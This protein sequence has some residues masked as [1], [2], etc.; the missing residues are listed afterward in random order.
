MNCPKCGADALRTARFCIRCGTPLKASSSTATEAASTRPMHE[1][2]TEWGSADA[3]PRLAIGQ[4]LPDNYRVEGELGIGGMGAVYLVRDN[5]TGRPF[6]VKTTRVADDAHRRG[7]LKE[8]QIWIDLPEHPNLVTCRFFRTIEDQVLI[9]ADYAN[10]G[11]LADAISRRTMTHLEQMLDVAIQFAWGLHAAHEVGVIHRDVKP[12]NVLLHEDGV[13]KITDFGISSAR[14][15]ATGQTVSDGT[16]GTVTSGAMTL[17]YRS[18]EQAAGKSL[19][20]ATDLWSWGVSLLEMFSGERTWRLGEV[21]DALLDQY[22]TI[23]PTALQ[24]PPMPAAVADLLRKCFRHDPDERW[25]DM[26]SV[27][28]MLIDIY[29]DVAGRAY[30]RQTP[31]F[32]RGPAES[33]DYSKPLRHEARDAEHWLRAALS[34]A[35]RDPNEAVSRLRKPTRLQAAR[36]VQELAAFDEA[37][38]MLERLVDEGQREQRDRL[39]KLCIDEGYVLRLAGDHNGALRLFDRS[40]AILERLLEASEELDYMST[41]MLATVEKGRTLAF[42]GRLSEAAEVFDR[43]I[44]Y[45]LM[46]WQPERYRMVRDYPLAQLFIAKGAVSFQERDYVAAGGLFSR[47]IDILEDM[48]RVWPRPDFVECLC[49]AYRNHSTVLSRQ[50][51]HEAAM[52]SSDRAVEAARM[53]RMK[54]ETALSD[55]D[56]AAVLMDRAAVLRE[57]GDKRSA[58]D[59]CER[60]VKLYERLVNTEGQQVLMPQLAKGYENLAVMMGSSGDHKSSLTM[61]D[62]AIALMTDLVRDH[63]RRDLEGTLAYIMVNRAVPLRKMRRWAEVISYLD[64]VIAE[65]KRLIEEEERVELLHELALAY[66]DQAYSFFK[67]ENPRSATDRFQRACQIWRVLVHERGRREL[68]TYLDK[69]ESNLRNLS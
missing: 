41:L 63:G 5:A 43:A 66:S 19:G 68:A 50:G 40:I 37:R 22:L 6:A 52:R 55:R 4:L 64:R 1:K 56:L 33:I 30:P 69:A 26:L 7:F 28:N 45:T 20:R 23:G 17:P 36:I 16:S 11:S 12:A 61:Y 53:L 18:P 31:D 67:Q 10:G 13:V 15:L 14:A 48:A 34:A 44:H 47:A 62:R 51:D 49:H 46:R 65:L 3:A 2:Q 8:L 57:R 58:R 21:A 32:V 59:V 24:L 54:Y 39:A 29:R 35:G 9:F 27:S 60:A 42:S 25:S 38:G